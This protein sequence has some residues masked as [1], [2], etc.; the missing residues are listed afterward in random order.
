MVWLLDM[1]ACNLLNLQK[2]TAVTGFNWRDTFFYFG[3][4]QVFI[5]Q[6][7]KTIFIAQKGVRIFPELLAKFNIIVRKTQLAIQITFFNSCLH[8]K[9]W[10]RPLQWNTFRS[11]HLDK[12]KKQ[13]TDLMPLYQKYHK[14]EKSTNTN[15]NEKHIQSKG[16][17]CFNVTKCLT[18]AAKLKSPS[19]N[20]CSSCSNH[21]SQT[22]YQI[23]WKSQYG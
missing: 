17:C 15:T 11:I 6:K 13:D 22:L 16:F 1:F 21:Y 23:L 14:W 12:K 5:I 9:R 4:I 3:F 20:S 19:S 18:E 7:I 8:F 10:N 2:H